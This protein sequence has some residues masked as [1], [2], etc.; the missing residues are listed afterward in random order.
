MHGELDEAESHAAQSSALAARAD[1]ENGFG[2]DALR[3]RLMLL[4]ND[5]DS[6]V[7]VLAH[8]SET[9]KTKRF[10]GR[11]KAGAPAYGSCCAGDRVE[12]NVDITHPRQART[13]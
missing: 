8:I 13:P 1:S 6:A 5:N 11:M 7:T 4:R 3:A 12:P 2:A 10:S 9:A